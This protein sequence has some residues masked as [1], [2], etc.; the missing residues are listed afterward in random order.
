ALRSQ[1]PCAP[2]ALRSRSSCV[3]CGPA[4]PA[5]LRFRRPCAPSRP[6]FP[7]VLRFLQ[8]RTPR[9]PALPAALHPPR[10]PGTAG[11]KRVGAAPSRSGWGAVHTPTSPGTSKGEPH[12]TERRFPATFLE[13]PNRFV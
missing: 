7:V 11:G 13:R 1:R 2:S 9:D 8:P 6:A 12:V 10:Q 3:S 5:T 4:R